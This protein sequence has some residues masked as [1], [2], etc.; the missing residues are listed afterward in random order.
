M[1]TASNGTLKVEEGSSSFSTPKQKL[2]QDVKSSISSERREFKAKPSNVTDKGSTSQVVS[3]SKQ[4]KH[5]SRD[6]MIEQFNQL[7]IDRKPLI[8]L[9]IIGH[10]DAGKSTLIGHLIYKLGC[11]SQKNMHRYETDSKKIGKASFLYAWILDETE[12]ERSRGITMDIA[13]SKF[14]TQNRIVNVLDAPGHR[15][16]IPNMIT[17][18][19]Q[20]DA[21]LLVVDAT[22]GEFEA[23]YHAGGQTR[24]HTLL[25]RSLG[26]SQIA[27]V[28]NKLDNVEYSQERYLTIVSKLT[29]FLKQAGFK[30]QDVNFVPCSGLTGE[31]LTTRCQVKSL[32]DWYNGPCLLEVIGKFGK[33]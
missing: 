14:E 7:R 20:A 15:D 22:C 17:G 9:V 28:I 3:A 16:F 5:I 2:T 19:A 11:I 25:I 21:S 4:I 32:R 26:V 30:E 1:F 23:G 24:E 12:E 6:Q 18:A 29:T 8:N 27:V 13:Q 33:K 10:V 31:N